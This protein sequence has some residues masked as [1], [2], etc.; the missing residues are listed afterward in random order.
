MVAPRQHTGT[1]VFGA[2]RR[3][4]ERRRRDAGHRSLHS[5]RWR[6]AAARECSMLR[7]RVQSATSRS[8]PPLALCKPRAVASVAHHE[9]LAVVGSAR[10]TGRV[11]GDAGAPAIPRE[12]GVLACRDSADAVLDQT[13]RERVASLP[14]EPTERS[15]GGRFGGSHPPAARA[16]RARTDGLGASRLGRYH[17]PS[18]APPPP[19]PPEASPLPKA[20]PPPTPTVRRHRHRGPPRQRPPTPPPPTPPPSADAVTAAQGATVRRHRP[21]TPSAD[22]ATVRR[23]RHRCRHASPRLEPR[24]ASAIQ[25][26]DASR[27]R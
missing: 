10:V 14:P 12:P 18:G 1:A 21:P 11:A 3:Q 26:V 2:N 5:G 15:D 23:R 19:P 6:G 22:A 25:R 4:I 16:A 27:V 13:V 8:L 20:P 7:A 9:L 24:R 17:P